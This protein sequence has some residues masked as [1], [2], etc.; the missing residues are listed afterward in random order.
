MAKTAGARVLGVRL[1]ATNARTV[2]T[3]DGEFVPVMNFEEAFPHHC[4]YVWCR[5]RGI[6]SASMGLKPLFRSYVRNCLG[7]EQRPA[8]CADGHH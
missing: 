5:A 8:A 7:A 6:F 2:Q 4:D 1:E 3:A